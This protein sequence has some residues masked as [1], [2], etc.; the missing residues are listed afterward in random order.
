METLNSLFYILWLFELP[1]MF[2]LHLRS[3][4]TLVIC[5]S[6]IGTCR[7]HSFSFENVVKTLEFIE[8]FHSFNTIYCLLYKRGDL[9]SIDHDLH[10]RH[11]WLMMMILGQNIHSLHVEM[12][13]FVS[14]FVFMFLTTH[15]KLNWIKILLINNLVKIPI[16]YKVFMS[17]FTLID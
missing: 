9:L 6:S 5:K 12:G 14:Y 11:S 10:N 13:S 16:S 4:R 7:F 17:F 8:L 15:S 1:F 3:C 2:V